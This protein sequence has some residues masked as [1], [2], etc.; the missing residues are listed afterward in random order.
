M[1]KQV[2]VKRKTAGLKSTLTT[3]TPV[4]QTTT[5]PRV[6]PI[7]KIISGT[8]ITFRIMIPDDAAAIVEFAST[9]TEAD[10]AYLRMDITKLEVVAVWLENISRHRTR[11]ILAIADDKIIGYGSIHHNVI[12][13]TRHI[14]EVR[15]LTHAHWRGDS[16]LRECLAGEVFQMA[17][18]QNLQRLYVEVPA[19][20]PHLAIVYDRLGFKSEALLSDWIM[21]SDGRTHDL[22]VM[23]MR[24]EDE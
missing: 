8:P 6:Y 18:E 16:E 15:I 19:D 2:E 4:P 1:M 10:V 12:L 14:G 13:W 3:A 22:V 9:L 7:S 23:S 5:V 20:R 17:K 11:T 21:T 24:L